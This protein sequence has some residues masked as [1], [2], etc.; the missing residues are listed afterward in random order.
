MLPGDPRTPRS[1]DPAAGTLPPVAEAGFEQQGADPGAA[2]AGAIPEHPACR[3]ASP[4]EGASAGE[5]GGGGHPVGGSGEA[6]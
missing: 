4:G 6:D 1:P 3:A 5:W 2:G